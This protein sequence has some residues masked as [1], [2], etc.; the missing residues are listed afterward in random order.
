MSCANHYYKS[1]N[2]SDS[3]YWMER[4]PKFMPGRCDCIVDVGVNFGHTSEFF[5]NYSNRV[6]VFEPSP[7]NVAKIEELIRIR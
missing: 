2:G 7:D 5:S 3:D 4:I 6:V 1:G